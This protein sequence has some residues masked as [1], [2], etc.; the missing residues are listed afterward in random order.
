MPESKQ[1]IIFRISSCS[2]C[3]K[4]DVCRYRKDYDL[5]SEYIKQLNQVHIEADHVVES[6]PFNL[7]I[8][9]GCEYSR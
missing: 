7:V 4:S 5:V 8:C 9:V 3:I 1:K 6:T 2:N